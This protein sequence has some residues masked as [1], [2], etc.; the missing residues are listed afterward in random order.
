LNKNIVIT[1][2]GDLLINVFSTKKKLL[3]NVKGKKNL[4]VDPKMLQSIER[5][6]KEGII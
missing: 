6:R 4:K 2:D 3:D 5:L 1:L